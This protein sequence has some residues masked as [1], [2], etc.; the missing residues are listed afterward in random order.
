V[1]LK[2]INAVKLRKDNPFGDPHFDKVIHSGLER[3]ICH[4]NSLLGNQIVI[5]FW[6]LFLTGR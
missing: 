6:Q 4:G 3:K 5:S 1:G 2:K